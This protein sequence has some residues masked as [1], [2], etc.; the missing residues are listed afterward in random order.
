MIILVVIRNI[1]DCCLCKNCL[2]KE[3]QQNG[4]CSMTVNRMEIQ[5]VG[6]HRGKRQLGGIG[7][8]WQN[9]VNVVLKEILYE[10]MNCV[11]LAKDTFVGVLF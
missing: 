3:D 9:S 6:K 2:L 1:G 7:H 8:R 5:L 4:V 11:Y 10:V